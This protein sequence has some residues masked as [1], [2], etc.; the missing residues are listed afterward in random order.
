MIPVARPWLGEEELEAVRAPLSN[1]WVT[2]GPEVAAFE[3]EFAEFV[4][5]PHAVAMSNCTSR[6][7][8][9]L[10]SDQW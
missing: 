4:H 7:S 5:A 3:K 2:Q 6:R 10:G 9:R 8:L 1:G